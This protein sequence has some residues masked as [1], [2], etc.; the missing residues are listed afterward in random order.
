MRNTAVPEI[1]KYVYWGRAD[2]MLKKWSLAS[3]E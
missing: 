2:M 3:F 1:N